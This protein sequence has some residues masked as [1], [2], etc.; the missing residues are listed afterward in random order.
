MYINGKFRFH[1]V[2]VSVSS[3]SWI[4]VSELVQPVP[5]QL[6]QIEEHLTLYFLQGH[7]MLLQSAWQLH[8]VIFNS[9]SGAGDR[10][11]SKGISF[12][13]NSSHGF[14][15]YKSTSACSPAA[16]MSFGVDVAVLNTL[17]CI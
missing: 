11:V 4:E 8:L 14:P 13:S 12:P 1:S 16:M 6:P 5:L 2:L 15:L 7:L 9:S 10:S 17:A 3:S